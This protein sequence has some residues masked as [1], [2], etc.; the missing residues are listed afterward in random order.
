SC[1]WTGAGGGEGG[2]DD[3]GDGVGEGVGSRAPLFLDLVVA[4]LEEELTSSSFPF[5]DFLK[6]LF[7]ILVD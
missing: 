5:L 2:G 6:M 1:S 7:L 3:E 4:V